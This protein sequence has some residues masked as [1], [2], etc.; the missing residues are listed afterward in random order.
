M[1]TETAQRR[2]RLVEWFKGNPQAWYDI[3]AELQRVLDD[4]MIEATGK[5]C[6][7]RDYMSGYCGG[8]QQALELRRRA[9]LWE[10][11]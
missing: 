2:Q 1:E 4:G 5:N 7:K 6:D 10:T 9:S 3:A 8:L 11:T